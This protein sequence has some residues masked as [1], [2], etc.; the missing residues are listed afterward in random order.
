MK[1][2]KYDFGYSC[3]FD[4]SDTLKIP[5]IKGGTIKY[6]YDDVNK[7]IEVYSMRNTLTNDGGRIKYHIDQSGSIKQ[8]D[9]YVSESSFN[10]YKYKFNYLNHPSVNFDALGD[11]TRMIYDGL[12]RLTV[13]INPDTSRTFNSYSYI[14]SFTNH[15]GTTPGVAFQQRF[16]DEEGNFFDKYTDA[17]G[18]LRREIKYIQENP[19]LENLTQLV[20]DYN[21]DSLYRVTQVKTPEGKFISYSY[22][23][24]GRQSKR[25]TPDAGQTDYS[26]DKNNNLT[27]TQDA[28]QRNVSSYKYTFRNYDGINRLTGIG[29]KIFEIDAPA[30]GG[31]FV[32]S[33]DDPYL[34]INVYDTLSSS[35][36]NNLFTA[37]A[38]YTSP[39]FT[40]GN[41]AATAY[42]TRST[43]TWNFKYYSYDVRGRVV[44]MWNIIDNFDTVVTRYD[45]NS[46]DQITYLT[47]QPGQN[48]FRKYHYEYDYT[49]R[50]QN[51][52]Y[53]TEPVEDNP[54]GY[55]ASFSSYS[56]NANSQI[57]QQ[58][59]GD[60]VLANNFSYNNRNWITFVQ[61][62]KGVIEYTNSYFKNG[63]VKTQ[64][65]NG[66]YKANFSNTSILSFDFTYDK[67]NRLLTMEGNN[68]GYDIENTYDKDGN[69]LTL[70]RYNS[71]GGLNDN[72]SYTYY[73]GTNKLNRVTG[74]T[75]QY[76]YDAN[77]N[78]TRDDVNRNADIKYDY[79]NL[80]TQLKHTEYELEDSIITVIYYQY[81][82]SGNRIR[83]TIYNYVGAGSNPDTP[84]I[85]DIG[86]NDDWEQIMD[87][88]YS[89][90]VDGKELAI[91]QSGN[92][93][94]WNVWG[95]DN[96]G[97]INSDGSKHYYLKDHLGSVRAV[98]DEN[99]DVVS[100]Q[101]YDA[102]GFLLEDRT[103]ESSETKHKFTGKERD[104]ESEYDYFGARYYDGRIGR[105]GQVDPL[106]Y[107]Y[108]GYS[109][110][111]Y[112]VDN[113]L[114][115][116]DRKGAEID[117]SRLPQRYRK[118]LINNL[119][120]I[121]GLQLYED[122][123]GYLK[124]TIKNGK[125]KTNDGSKTANKIIL[126]AIELTEVV[127]VWYTN[128]GSSAG[129][130]SIKLD[131]QQI[132]F[133]VD[134]TS[135][136][137]NKN[138]LGWGMVFIHEYLHTTPG[139]SLSDPKQYG[140]I[141]EV[142][143]TMNDIREELGSDY[144]MRASYQSLLLDDG[145]RYIPFSTYSEELI[146]SGK[147]P[148]AS[149]VKSLGKEGR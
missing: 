53:W 28:N 85:G 81:D 47:Y 136:D 36:V 62:S 4:V 124:Y 61:D 109:P 95:S 117:L 148:S 100:A 121:T 33:D 74:S 67:S 149:F 52:S 8:K 144:G 135:S 140:L 94:Q 80:I 120:L 99:T 90:G 82:E 29:E 91:Y 112:V 138:T 65:F 113:P 20:T 18:N 16:T 110:Y 1:G 115:F 2:A 125:P 9:I 127:D 24:Y 7:T 19:N 54:A 137:L 49:G 88:I 69:L 96:I 3:K 26:Y 105:W 45:Y 63:N 106:S 79:R 73:S 104:V 145:F 59:Y 118:E 84:P 15:F 58:V 101:D 44:K 14:G 30:D 42:R 146:Q 23:G 25:I 103:Y 111:C 98:I 41:L 128:Q 50:L 123:K 107:K 139:G 87:E 77:G 133:Y 129:D 75:A 122:E 86:G 31:Q 57:E 147:I 76:T 143:Y 97:K 68:K 22:D 131:A 27:Y 51:V 56:Y 38:G 21:Y 13:T 6:V 72:F 64:E 32:S 130:Y 141:G 55:Y 17:A 12:E 11:S 119:S 93:V 126:D 35:I 34:T 37:P 60:A 108:I 134:N 116:I 114:L 43:D 71:S 83:K 40:K 70:K 10:S 5:V 89:R 142:E 66:N 48:D 46:Q 39:L 132:Q 78:M 102:W 92:L